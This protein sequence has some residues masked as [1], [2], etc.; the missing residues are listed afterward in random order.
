MA[1]RPSIHTCERLGMR[2]VRVEGQSQR[3]TCLHEAH[4]G[5]LMA[6]HATLVPFGLS[7]PAFHLEVV[8]RQVCLF[9]AYN[10]PGSTA[11]HDATHRLPN[12]IMARLEL[13][14]QDLKWRLTLRTR[15]TVWVKCRLDR[16]H[17]L[18]GGPHR[19]VGVMD[20][21]QTSRNVAC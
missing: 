20:R 7:K 1:I 17:L 10:Q 12:G 2:Q 15:A 13:L 6:M 18:H 9:A 11:G 21:C 5:V 3:G 4:P 8:P 19:F 16:P 14:L